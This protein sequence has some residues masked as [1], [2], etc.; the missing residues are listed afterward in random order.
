MMSPDGKDR[1]NIDELASCEWLRGNNEYNS[2]ETRET[3][4]TQFNEIR[5]SQMD[6]TEKKEFEENAAKE[7]KE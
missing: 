4:T 2:K 1:P 3:L 5:L 6:E 7:A